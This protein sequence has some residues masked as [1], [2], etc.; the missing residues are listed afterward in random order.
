S[1]VVSCAATT[2]GCTTCRR[3]CRVASA[4]CS[5][6]I[7]TTPPAMRSVTARWRSSRAASIVARCASR[8]PTRCVPGW[9]ACRTAG[10][11][12][13]AR[14]GRRWPAATLGCPSTT[15]STTRSSSRSSASRSST[16]CRCVSGRRVLW[17][18]L[19]TP[20]CS[21]KPLQ[22]FGRFLG[23]FLQH[24]VSSVLQ[25]G[26]GHIRGDKFRL[27][28]E[29][30]SESLL[31]ADHEE[32]HRQL[33]LREFGEVLCRLRK[34]NEVGPARPHASGPGVSASTSGTTSPPTKARS[35]PE[36]DR[37]TYTAAY[38]RPGR[39]RAGWA[40]FVSFPQAAKDFAEL[41]QTKLPMPLLVIGGEKALGGV[42]GEQAKLVASDVTVTVLKDTGHWV[43]EERPKERPTLWRSF[44]EQ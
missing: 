3:W 15:G 33:R 9:S 29:Y 42:L 28:T 37:K 6:F 39:M 4:A 19:R 8:S 16:A 26:D 40:Y 18:D 13:T 34:R 2:P 12:R 21:E 44:S 5:M 11:M 1:A 22:S 27:L 43:L 25:H 14:R 31:A 32:R 20:H 24:P 35:I 30:S 36:A 38:S 17:P 10:A 41:S 23:P 7:P